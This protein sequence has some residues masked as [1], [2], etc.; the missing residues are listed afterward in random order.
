MLIDPSLAPGAR[1]IHPIEPDWG[2][3]HVQSVIGDRITVN[4]EN[5]GKVVVIA[6]L[7]E[8]EIVAEAAAAGGGR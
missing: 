8:L 1:V 7:V 3:G 6:T 4:F 2:I 5:R